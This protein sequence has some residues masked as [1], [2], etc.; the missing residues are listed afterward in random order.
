MVTLCQ[1][2]DELYVFGGIQMS[3]CT[4]DGHQKIH[5]PSLSPNLPQ[6]AGICV[7][8]WQD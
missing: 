5:P 6:A 7:T 1:A 2:L 8:I 4:L 3:I